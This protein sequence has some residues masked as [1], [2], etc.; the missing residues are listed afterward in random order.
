LNIIDPVNRI[1]PS[2]IT[3]VTILERTGKEE[4]MRLL[5]AADTDTELAR[6]IK[7]VSLDSDVGSHGFGKCGGSSNGNSS[8]S[9]SNN[10]VRDISYVCGHHDNGDANDDLLAC[11][12]SIQRMNSYVSMKIQSESH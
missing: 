12:S 7:D 6:S 5:T 10:G 2:R 1:I 4:I 3:E 11:M 9:E 8:N